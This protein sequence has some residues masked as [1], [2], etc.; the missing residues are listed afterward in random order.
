MLLFPLQQKQNHGRVIIDFTVLKGI[1][2]SYRRKTITREIFTRLW[3]EAQ[4]QF[5]ANMRKEI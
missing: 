2:A 3:A 4:E 1:I 5:A